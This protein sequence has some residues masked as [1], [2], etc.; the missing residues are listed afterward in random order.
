[1][2]T[3]VLWEHVCKYK[4]CLLIRLRMCWFVQL[5]KLQNARCND[6]NNTLTSCGVSGYLSCGLGNT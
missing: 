6:K 5:N 3:L 4:I 2:L 1:M